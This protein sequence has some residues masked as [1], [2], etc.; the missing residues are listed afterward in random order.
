MCNPCM[1]PEPVAAGRTAP[2]EICGEDGWA[3]KPGRQLK[4][5]PAY[6][7]G[8]AWPIQ[9]GG[10]TSALFSQ[11]Q[12]PRRTR[13]I[14]AARYGKNQRKQREHLEDI[15]G[16][17][18]PKVKNSSG[19]YKRV[20]EHYQKIADAFGLVL[21]PLLPT[22]TPNY[23]EGMPLLL[24]RADFEP[25]QMDSIE[26]QTE[27]EIRV[28]AQQDPLWGKYQFHLNL[29]QGVFNGDS[30]RPHQDRAIR[31]VLEH[32]GSYQTIALPTGYGKTRIGQAITYVL[33]QEKQGP[34][35]MISPIIALRDDQ[36]EAFEKT[37]SAD[38]KI[39]ARFV[40]AAEEKSR[41]D[42]VHELL[43]NE[44][45]LLCCAPEQLLTPSFR[46][47]WV[48]IFSR[49]RTPFSTLIIDEAHL[50]GDWG[51]SIRPQFLLLGM[52]RDVL[53]TLN[54]HLRIIVQ[55]A[56]I[57][58]NENEE[59]RRLF[60]ANRMHELP[61]I[62][63]DQIRDDLHFRVVRVQKESYIEKAVEVILDEAAS[64]K[65][66]WLRTWDDRNDTGSPPFIVYSAT[67]KDAREH[68]LPKLRTQHGKRKVGIYD[69]DTAKDTRETLRLDFKK[70]KFKALVAT[71]AFG[72]GIDKPDVWYIGYVGLPHTLKGLYQG[73]GRA[74]RGSNWSETDEVREPRA[75]VCS[76]IIPIQDPRSFK[77]ELGVPYAAERTWDI[78]QNAT[79][80]ENRG[81]LIAPVLSHLHEVLWNQNPKDLEVYVQRI[82]AKRDDDD[83]E[84]WDVDLIEDARENMER[85]LQSARDANMKY[86][87]WS[88]A[89]LQRKGAVKIHGFFPQVLWKCERT[90][91]EMTLEEAL[92]QGGVLR[93]HEELR[94][95]GSQGKVQPPTQRRDAVL[96]FRDHV[97]DWGQMIDIVQQAH[98]ALKSR[99]QRGRKELSEFL[100]GVDNK[101][102]IRAAFAPAIGGG[103]QAE[104]TCTQAFAAWK[105]ESAQGLPPV[106][107]A[108]C[109]GKPKFRSSVDSTSNILW[110]DKDWSNRLLGIEEAVIETKLDFH[111]EDFLRVPLGWESVEIDEDEHGAKVVPGRWKSNAVKCIDSD[112]TTIQPEQVKYHEHQITIEEMGEDD[113]IVL[114]WEKEQIVRFIPREYDSKEEWDGEHR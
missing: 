4:H 48:E 35:L 78:V 91:D 72:M 69:G 106:P 5:I 11:L 62:R 6:S 25:Y 19:K 97:Q 27:R 18:R 88:L 10:Q 20:F 53:T 99:H 81:L 8:S 95:I 89:L 37:F 46:A 23:T 96:S 68:L 44:I 73:F 63:E 102:C 24:H 112:G 31:Q 26:A 56:T 22:R 38:N 76:A 30:L 67:K 49:M 108:H 105:E 55:S 83:D 86:M 66:K 39:R 64:R 1:A 16:E 47:A 71:S 104:R 42:I 51:A 45:D 74:A 75:G 98:D 12:T 59:L 110:A 87:L 58:E 34:T 28:K 90:H 93:V 103:A 29:I 41:D 17:E 111:H 114:I 52:I 101:E 109:M 82:L 61:V 79:V 50:V 7:D 65:L 33:R 36:R 113:N 85:G 40:T 57:T 9:R 54:P 100:R 107:C 94:T 60:S 13:L 92:K 14:S 15:F 80:I 43:Q 21:T 2:C 3:P 84:E 70:N 32:Q 77:G